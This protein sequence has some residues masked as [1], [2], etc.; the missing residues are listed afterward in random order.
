MARDL[1]IGIDSST[2]ATK[3][4]AWDRTGAPVAEGRAAIP[5]AQPRPRYFEQDPEDWWSSTYLAL[6]EL[7]AKVEPARIAGVAISNQRETFGVFDEHGNA[8]RPAIVWL[9]ERAMDQMRRFGASFGAEKIHAISGKPVDI[10]PCLYR[11]V[12]LRENEP[13]VLNRAAYV[14]E[15]HG[16]LCFRLTG[17]WATSTASADPLGVLDMERLVWSQ[18]ILAAAGIP[19]DKMLPMMRP[20][21]LI[22]TVTETAAQ[23]TGLPADT[24]VFAG[25]GDGQ[26]AGT[27]VDVLRSGRTY[28][29]LGTAVVSGHYSERYVFD[30]AFRTETAVADR[31]YIVE[32]CLRSGTFLLDWLTRELLGLDPQREL[33]LLTALEAEAA[34]SPVG[35]NGVMLVPYWEGCMTPHWDASARGVIAGLSGSTRRGDLYRALLEGV[36]LE[37]ALASRR[38]EAGC[39][40]TIDHYVAVGGGTA[41]NLWMQILADA[42]GVPVHRSTNK[43]ASA[44]GAAIAAAT[45]CG[46]FRSFAEASTAMAGH[47]DRTFEPK[48]TEQAAYAELSGIYEELW[49]ALSSWN[50]KLARLVERRAAKPQS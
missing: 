39:G 14:A 44:L 10:T 28:I 31:G 49:P 23:A 42:T 2:T 6:R 46:W 1:V 17:R 45:G 41:S 35:S 37:Q 5:L 40:Q 22:G 26:C 29:N 27:G 12:W 21:A 25:G 19:I 34:R 50:Q 8:I 33:E 11:M 15:V 24:L 16:Y 36:A 3:A 13:N 48:P 32:T 9:D 30:R 47:I 43:E 20:G 7:T 18:E 4:I 38:L